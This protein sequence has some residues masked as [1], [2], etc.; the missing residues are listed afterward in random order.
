MRA[1]VNE[2]S[3]VQSIDRKLKTSANMGQKN[4]NPVENI[5]S[6]TVTIFLQ[7][8]SCIKEAIW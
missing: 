6:L 3:H 8:V 4:V 7:G 5:Q 1:L 2:L